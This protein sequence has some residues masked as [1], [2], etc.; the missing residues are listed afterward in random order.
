MA[1]NINQLMNDKSKDAARKDGATFKIEHID[2]GRL[3]PS[4]MNAYTVNDVTELKAS[5]ELQGLQQNLVVR[6]TDGGDFEVIS[7]HRRLKAMQELFTEGNK[8]FGKVPC[9]VS[10]PLDDLQAELE[11]ILANATARELT[12][13]EKTYQSTRLQELL[14]EMRK[15]GY[16]IKGR[17]REIV[18]EWL[19]V[20]S[21]QI[22]HM[23]SINKKLTPALKEEF[24]AE[25]INITTAYE[26]SRLPEEKQQEVVQEYKEGK[27]LTPSI[28]KE[29]RIESEQTEKSMTHEMDSYPAQFEAVK[30]GLKTFLWGFGNQSY[31]VGDKLKINEFDDKEILYTGK[32]VEARIT[33]I[34]IGGTNG[35]PEDYLIMSIKKIK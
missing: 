8:Q 16:P 10:V 29:K 20:S 18:A 33:Y 19:G 28:A 25:N 27:A 23:D 15:S 35:I 17:K 14:T 26:L 34:E 4:K 21:S 1:F 5:I 32:F 13:Y 11:L 24:K 31:K 12:D 22:Q 7:G 2:I 9:K 6:K 3:K 30:A